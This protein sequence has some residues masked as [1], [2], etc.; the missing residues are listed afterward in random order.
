METDINNK[1]EEKKFKFTPKTISKLSLI[2]NKMEISKLLLEINVE[3]GDQEKDKELVVRKLLALVIDNL[4]K[5]EDEI[6][7]F[8]A[9]TMK[10]SKEDAADVD[11]IPLIKKIVNDDNITSFLKLT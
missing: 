1:E 4:Y 3:S 7:E 9:D 2:I 11:I 6:I 8:V 5:A 10:I